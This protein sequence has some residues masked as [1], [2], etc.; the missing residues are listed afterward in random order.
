MDDKQ[1]DPMA[2]IEKE[3]FG[4]ETH[5]QKAKRILTT[6]TPFAAAQI[7]NLAMNG[8][9]DRIRL[10]ASKTILDRTL[11]PVGKDTQEDVLND[12]LEGIQKLSKEG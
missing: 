12:F 5:A 8:S 9:S 6:N 10:E 3:I 7:V 11:G 1:Y 2:E 4:E